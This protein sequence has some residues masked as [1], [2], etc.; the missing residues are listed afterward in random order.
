MTSVWPASLETVESVQY[1]PDGT[2]E[3]L[4]HVAADTANALAAIGV[5]G[6]AR[7]VDVVRGE[8][9]KKGLVFVLLDEADSFLRERF[10]HQLI[11]PAGRLA[12][13]H[14]TDAADAVDDRIVVALAGPHFEKFRMF[15]AG[16][17][18]ADLMGIAGTNGIAR[19]EADNPVVLDENA[20]HPVA[21]GREE[22]GVIEAQFERAWLDFLVE[23]EVAFAKA[24]VPFTDE[25]GT[26]AGLLED[27][28]CGRLGGVHRQWRLA[29]EDAGAGRVCAR[30]TGR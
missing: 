30:R 21:G 9:E 8:V 13:A 28:G 23:V 14:P 10:G 17:F 20:R 26:V 16:G 1:G 3:F 6:D 12:A 25:A 15:L 19:V 4:D 7:D 29:V 22:E 27:G 24:D 2:V 18:V 11:H 5:A